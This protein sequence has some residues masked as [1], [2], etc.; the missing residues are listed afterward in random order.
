M[1]YYEIYEI[2]IDFINDNDF[3]NIMSVSKSLLKICKDSL[4][5][6]LL[7]NDKV[8]HAFKRNQIDHVKYLKTCNCDMRWIRNINWLSYAFNYC[9]DEMIKFLIDNNHDTLLYNNSCMHLSCY[10]GKIEIAKYL[11][12]RGYNFDFECYKYAKN[13]K[14]YDILNLIKL[15]DFKSQITILMTLCIGTGESMYDLIIF[16][17]ISIVEYIFN[18]IN[19]LSTT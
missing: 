4:R 6:S 3:Y 14:H 16:L 7:M 8:I 12:S 18:N 15:N 17:I 2:I 10:H 13:M 19:F 11:V 1:L 9:N 5:M